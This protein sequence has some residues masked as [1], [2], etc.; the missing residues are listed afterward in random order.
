MKIHV[1]STYFYFNKKKKKK[2]NY[3]CFAI[4]QL[5]NTFTANQLI[6]DKLGWDLNTQ[7][8]N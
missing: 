1:N 6:N 3:S 4:L 2:L 7:I 8:N 5:K